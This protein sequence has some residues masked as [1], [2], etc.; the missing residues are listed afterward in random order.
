MFG[1]FGWSRY[2]F[3]TL[4][5]KKYRKASPSCPSILS[6]LQLWL[7][8]QGFGSHFSLSREL[9]PL[10]AFSLSSVLLGSVN[11]N[12]VHDD[13]ALLG[14]VDGNKDLAAVICQDRNHWFI[15]CS[16]TGEIKNEGWISSLLPQC[17]W[18]VCVTL[19]NVSRW[20]L[21]WEEGSFFWI[22]APQIWAAWKST[23]ELWEN[24]DSPGLI[25]RYIDLIVQGRDKESVFFLKKNKIF[26]DNCH[27]T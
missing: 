27:V 13:R 9:I 21:F 18:M 26:S 16:Y 17:R 14:R 12:P 15:G 4:Q 23:G 7:F 5:T 19:T 20:F 24:T 8:G 22:G 2:L 11:R 10:S 3:T 6:D 25:F 1:Y